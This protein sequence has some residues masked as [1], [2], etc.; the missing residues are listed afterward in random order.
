MQKVGSFERA[1]YKNAAYQA[2]CVHAGKSRYSHEVL[3]P[4]DCRRPNSV[5]RYLWPSE[6]EGSSNATLLPSEMVPVSVAAKNLLRDGR[7]YWYCTKDFSEND[8]DPVAVRAEFT[9]GRP[10]DGFTTRQEQPG[11]QE[12]AYRSFVQSLYP[13]LKSQSDS[14]LAVYFGGEYLTEFEIRSELAKDA[15]WSMLGMCL[16]VLY[17]LLHTQSMFVTAAGVL[18]I[19]ISYPISYFFYRSA[20]GVEKVGVLAYLSL[21]LI[22]GIG[23]DDVFVW[24]DNYRSTQLAGLTAPGSCDTTQRISYAWRRAAG[25]ML[26]TSATTSAAFFANAASAIPAVRVFGCFVGVMVIVNFLMVISFFPCAVV[27]WELRVRPAEVK[28]YETCIGALERSLPKLASRVRM[29]TGGSTITHQML[30]G[31]VT[32]VGEPAPDGEETSKVLDEGESLVQKYSEG[33]LSI[34]YALIAAFMIVTAVGFALSA[35]VQ[36]A[37]EVPNLFPKDHNVQRFIDW[38]TE[39]FYTTAETSCSECYIE[40]PEQPK[41]ADIPEED[42][43]LTTAA[44]AVVYESQPPPPFLSPPPTT[45]TTSQAPVPGGGGDGGGSGSS[46]SLPTASN[47]PPSSPPPPQQPITPPPGPPPPSPP[48]PVSGSLGPAPIIRP[49]IVSRPQ[50]ESVAQ[51]LIRVTFQRPLSGMKPDLYEI[52]RIIPAD[53]TQQPV[54]AFVEAT[55]WSLEM[56]YDDDDV[57]A[58]TCYEYSVRAIVRAEG[59]GG[60]EQQA[61]LFSTAASNVPFGNGLPSTPTG[62]VNTANAYQS[63][64]LQWKSTSDDGRYYQIDVRSESSIWRSVYE[65]GRTEVFVGEL[66]PGTTFDMRIRALNVDPNNPS[67]TRTSSWSSIIQ[68][69]TREGVG[70]S[71]PTSFSLE[72]DASAPPALRAKW[73]AAVSRGFRTS[74]YEVCYAECVDRA[75]GTGDVECADNNFVTIAELGDACSPM[76]VGMAEDAI[77]IDGIVPG[78]QYAVAVRGVH[79]SRDYG[80]LLGE[81]SEI[82][83]A[84]ALTPSPPPPPPPVPFPPPPFPPPPPSPPPPPT[85]YPSPPSPPPSPPPPSL[86]KAFPMIMARP[87]TLVYAGADF[88][89]LGWMAIPTSDDA[90]SLTGY[91]VQVTTRQDCFANDSPVIASAGVFKG[92]SGALYR[93]APETVYCVRYR[94]TAKEGVSLWSSILA[95]AR[96]RAVSAPGQWP[97]PT[98]LSSLARTVAVAWW[99][100]LPSSDGGRPTVTVQ[101]INGRM[102]TRPLDDGGSPETMRYELRYRTLK[103]SRSPGGRTITERGVWMTAYQGVDNDAIVGEGGKLEPNATYEIS[104][105]AS[106]EVGDGAW[107]T[108]AQVKT[109]PLAAS[110]GGNFRVESATLGDGKEILA[111]LPQPHPKIPAVVG[112]DVPEASGRRHLA[113]FVDTSVPDIGYPLILALCASDSSEDVTFESV[114]REF[115]ADACRAAAMGSHRRLAAGIQSQTVFL[116]VPL[117][118]QRGVND[119]VSDVLSVVSWARRALHVRRERGVA[120]YGAGKM[121][122]VAHLAMLENPTRFR[123]AGLILGDDDNGQLKLQVATSLTLS[124]GGF[125]DL[126][127][128]IQDAGGPCSGASVAKQLSKDLSSSSWRSLTSPAAERSGFDALAEDTLKFGVA[129]HSDG[130]AVPVPSGDVAAWYNTLYETAGGL[131]SVSE[132]KDNKC[133]VGDNTRTDEDVWPGYYPARV[134]SAHAMAISLMLYVP[135][136]NQTLPSNP[137]VSTAEE[138]GIVY[139]IKGISGGGGG[140]AG[141]R[142]LDEAKA[143]YDGSLDISS[144][145][146]QVH[147]LSVCD[148]LASWREEVSRVERCWPHDFKAW[149]AK[150]SMSYPIA[151]ED[152]SSTL[153]RSQIFSMLLAAFINE[154]RLYRFDFDVDDAAVAAGNLTLARFLDKSR[155]GYPLFS[156]RSSAGAVPFVY[157]RIKWSRLV[158]RLTVNEGVSGNVAMRHYDAWDRWITKQRR[159]QPKSLGLSGP[160]HACELWVRAATEKEAVDST[161]LAIGIA[162]AC[163]AIAVSVFT[164]D[165]WLASLL[166]TNILC[167]VGCVLGSFYLVGWKLGAIEALSVTVLVGLSCDFALHVAEAYHQSPVLLSRRARGKCA[168]ERCIMPCFGA[169]LT[170]LLAALPL[171]GCTVVILSKFGVLISICISLSLLFSMH[172]LVPLLM[173]FGPT[174]SDQMFKNPWVAAGEALF[175]SN[176]LR[177]L[178]VSGGVA[179]LVGAMVKEGRMW[180]S[181]YPIFFLF[182]ALLLVATLAEVYA[183]RKRSALM[184]GNRGGVDRGAASSSG[185]AG[186]ELGAMSMDST[187]FNDNEDNDADDDYYSS[188]HR[189][190]ASSMS[191]SSPQHVATIAPPH[192]NFDA[193]AKAE[194]AESDSAADVREGMLTL[195]TATQAEQRIESA[196]V[197]MQSPESPPLLIPAEDL[198]MTMQTEQKIESVTISPPPT[199][200]SPQPPPP[201]ERATPRPASPFLAGD[202]STGPQATVGNSPNWLEESS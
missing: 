92:E 152:G 192:E 36:P 128:Y 26:V 166:M 167:I 112:T 175:W 154:N 140:F 24:F 37:S 50:V 116:V 181:K 91:Q 2:Q 114:A 76:D 94:A 145:E 83:T 131:V 7:G 13:F 110:D 119:L 70:P 120:C 172:L 157:P 149:L 123:G 117:D 122:L 11:A 32:E 97:P 159:T 195:E 57:D 58:Y 146:S 60:S 151:Y 45:T 186:I 179:V 62:L 182:F 59:T 68:A 144:V 176:P 46:G 23:V 16:V 71:A 101:S 78:R 102:V 96:T 19:A 74:L 194:T 54:F 185:F 191:S 174:W 184:F 1:L 73:F 200:S 118:G 25:T 103:T 93:L 98:V 55:D 198:E 135:E 150:R 138:L 190:Q 17:M 171:L 39:G 75:A 127:V 84:Y 15:Q 49:G 31:S 82:R 105:R 147:L 65:G 80:T 53:L 56:T 125:Q 4:L 88:L 5:T 169:C 178:C 141:T 77:L 109:A 143:L 72:A 87:P 156:I 47:P 121:A 90:I 44:P 85:L 29:W 95:G 168:F 148:E 196:T 81:Y 48:P 86:N 183:S 43:P 34:R 139:G 129:K 99:G 38:G 3:F 177:R 163:A 22:V 61:G 187:M 164:G 161:K 41:K 160:F 188:I 8:L 130:S 155:I 35:Q 12:A 27:Y 28:L 42:V 67:S 63:L 173:T 133:A 40:P 18:Q 64:Y 153:E 202:V 100:K 104:V 108:P 10:V 162:I 107:S 126:T 89:Y 20:M 21:F 30:T 137:M 9:F 180:Y 113:Q 79:K 14:D 51:N 111:L 189:K 193:K 33:I 170:T 158:V 134:A 6:Y 199:E 124:Q 132:P 197:A 52:L 66:R 69:Y 142:R 106:N 136:R 201:E 165:V 115:G